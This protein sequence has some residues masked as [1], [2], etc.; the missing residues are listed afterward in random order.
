MRKNQT[1]NLYRVRE[2]K[3]NFVR[4]VLS[5]NLQNALQE[6]VKNCLRY[7]FMHETPGRSRGKIVFREI[8]WRTCLLLTQARRDKSIQERSLKIYRELLFPWSTGRAA[9]EQKLFTE[10]H[11]SLVQSP[12]ISWPVFRFC[13]SE[14]GTQIFRLSCQAFRAL[15]RSKGKKLFKEVI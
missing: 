4:K 9:R 6:L 7:A 1:K 11:Q 10:H 15:G 14:N 5:G 3:K 8:L 13:P 12:K 2:K